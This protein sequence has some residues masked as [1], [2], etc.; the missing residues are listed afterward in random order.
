MARQEVKFKIGDVVTIAVDCSRIRNAGLKV[1]QQFKLVAHPRY[2]T[3]DTAC[4][5]QAHWFFF[6][7]G[8]F[9]RHSEDHVFYAYFLD[10]EDYINIPQ[11]CLTCGDPM[12]LLDNLPVGNYV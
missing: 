3:M 1:G 11:D 10:G 4:T 12:V 8:D 2:K 5:P 9:R 6:D 7:N